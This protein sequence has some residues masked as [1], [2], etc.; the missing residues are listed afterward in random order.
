MVNSIVKG[1]YQDNFK[2]FYLFFYGKISRYISRKEYCTTMVAVQCRYRQIL[3]R[4]D[5]E[6][7]LQT[8]VISVTLLPVGWSTFLK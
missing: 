7:L 6:L 2:P 1:G 8:S 4:T 5:M 3:M